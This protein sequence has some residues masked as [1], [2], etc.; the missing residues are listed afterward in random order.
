MM[1]LFGRLKNAVRSHRYLLAAGTAAAIVLSVGLTQ[2]ALAATQGAEFNGVYDLV[3]AWSV[4]GLG[5]VISLAFLLVG[6]AIGV[7]R[8]SVLAAV[9][10]IAAAVALLLGPSI[11]D[12]LFTT[13][14][15]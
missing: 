5:K 10:T 8:G 4:G 2:D 13:A 1:K 3:K 7:L 14:G 6:L 12:A 15:G 9:S 11:I